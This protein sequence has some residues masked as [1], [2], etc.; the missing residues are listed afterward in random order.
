VVAKEDGLITLKRALPCG[1]DHW[2]LIHRQASCQEMTPER[3]FYLIDDGVSPIPA[4]FLPMLARALAAPVLSG[5]SEY[6][7]LRGRISLL[8]RPLTDGCLGLGGWK[9]IA[10]DEQ[11]EGIIGEGLKHSKLAF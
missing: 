9:V 1:W 6:L 3:P 10:D 7:W 8:V 5:W 4:A 11:W 2:C